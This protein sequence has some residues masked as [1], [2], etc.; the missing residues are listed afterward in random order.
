MWQSLIFFSLCA[1][2]IIVFFVVVV[3]CFLSYLFDSVRVEHFFSF[4]HPLGSFLS[5]YYYS[6]SGSYCHNNAY[7]QT[8]PRL[9]DFK[10]HAFS[11]GLTGMWFGCTQSGLGRYLGSRFWALGSRHQVPGSSLNP[12]LSPM[13]L[14]S[15]GGEVAQ[16]MWW[17]QGVSFRDPRWRGGIS[18]GPV[19]S[20]QGTRPK[21][22]S[23]MEQ[24]HIR[25]LVVSCLLT[26]C[27]SKQVAQP[28]PKSGGG[29]GQRRNLPF[30]RI[31]S[32][33]G[34]RMCPQMSE[35]PGPKNS[36]FYRQRV[37]QWP[38]IVWVLGS[39]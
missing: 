39:T 31:W 37:S 8:T 9:S 27:G 36:I 16:G 10:Q 26:S 1:M 30:K 7:Q 22:G 14:I 17:T 11:L 6:V 13:P 12:V 34:Y 25:P 2:V 35:D 4:F 32:R 24:T 20:W 15:H 33:C 18:V 21:K 23:L 28:N 29:G 3:V 5:S 38:E 19:F